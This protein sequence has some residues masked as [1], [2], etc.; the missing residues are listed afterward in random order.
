MFAMLCKYQ[1]CVA[2][3]GARLLVVLLASV[4]LALAHAGSREGTVYFLGSLVVPA[5]VAVAGRFEV[6]L[7]VVLVALVARP[8]QG[9]REAHVHLELRGLEPKL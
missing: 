3:R 6:D 4:L 7:L 1:Y 9:L 2:A 8:F 5:P